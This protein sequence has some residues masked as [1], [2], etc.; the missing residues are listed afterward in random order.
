MSNVPANVNNPKLYLSIKAKLKKT[1]KSWPS[2]YGS[3]LLVKQYKSAGGTYSGKKPSK[4]T[5]LTRW[6]EEKW[7]DVCQYPKIQ[8]CGRPKG[9][10][11]NY[12]KDFPYCRPLVRVNASTPKT[13]KELSKTQRDKYC[14][15]KKRAPKKKMSS[16]LYSN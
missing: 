6:F 4:Q 10:Y 11:K 8:P 14:A 13:V 15:L 1:V 3:G 2:A 9:G 12:A 5:G 7:V 16:V